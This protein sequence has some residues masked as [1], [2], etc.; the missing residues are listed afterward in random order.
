VLCQGHA[1][2]MG[3]A[4]EVFKLDEDGILQIL[5]PRFDAGQ[6][7]AVERAVKYCPNQAL[8]IVER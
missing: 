8:R 4:P 7:E 1:M 3:E 2:C 6:R 5:K